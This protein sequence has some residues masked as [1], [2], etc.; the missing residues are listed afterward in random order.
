MGF[1]GIPSTP[2]PEGLQY[3]LIDYDAGPVFRYGDQSG[4][5]TKIPAIKR[6]LPQLVVRV[7][8]DGNE[9]AG[10]R[11]PLLMA[12]LGTYTGW[13]VA[14]S[15]VF[16]GQ[17]CVTGAPVGGFIPFASTRAEREARRDPRLS[18]EERYRDHEGYV[19]AVS[20]ATKTLVAEGYLL[21]GDASEMIAQAA[22]SDILK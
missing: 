5:A 16:K 15:G 21:P 4:V 20:E 9:T 2:S 11:S 6:T 7:D 19:R 13:N 17:I 14:A 1:P 22:A 3:P 18:L 10:I 8:Q 12:P